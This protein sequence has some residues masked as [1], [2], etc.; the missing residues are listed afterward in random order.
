MNCPFCNTKDAKVIDSRGIDSGAIIRRR[1]ECLHCKKR[2]TSY[3]RVERSERLVVI[4]KDG[5]RVPFELQKILRGIRSACGKR[6]IPEEVKQRVADE[7]DDAIHREFEREV[8]SLAIGRRVAM[9]L[10]NVDAV[11]YVR[12]ASVYHDFQSVSEFQAEISDLS[13]KPPTKAHEP[14]L[15][16]HR[17]PPTV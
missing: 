2:F 12:F 14:L 8:H 6:P 16:D 3:E 4:K 15:F 5:S 10:R 17:T 11:A 9:A 7:I 1:R 13:E